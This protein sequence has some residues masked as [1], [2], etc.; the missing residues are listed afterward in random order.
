MNRLRNFVATCTAITL[1]FTL[2]YFLTWHNNAKKL[3][4][5]QPFHAIIFDMDGTII[6]TDHLW[7]NA[8]GPIL[9]SHAPHLTDDEKSAL[10]ANFSHLTIYEVW[11]LIGENCSIA[12]SPEQ[13]IDEN[14]RHLHDLYEKHGVAFIPHFD[15]FH[16]KA[17]SHGLKTAIASNSQQQT[18]DVIIKKVPLKNYFKEHMYNA[19]HVN[20]VYKPQPD[21]YLHAAKMLNVAPCHCI[22]IEDSASGIKA[23]K[24]AGMYCIGINTGKNRNALAQADE[25]VDCYQ[26]IN[27]EK[28][29]N[30]SRS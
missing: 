23:A 12:L 21:V 25:I 22:A 27:L 11:K 6:D 16:K 17:V 13:I 19:D 20:K 15:T 3:V 5:A 8:N 4:N 24:A 7:K 10:I 28:L 14:I 29:L 30:L 2:S 26:H 18:M 1:F 9:D